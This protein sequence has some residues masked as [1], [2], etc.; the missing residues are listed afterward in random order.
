MDKKIS[1]VSFQ[2]EIDMLE[3]IIYAINGNEKVPARNCCRQ[4]NSEP[5]FQKRINMDG[6][7]MKTLL[8][9]EK[10]RHNWSCIPTKST[11]SEEKI[12]SG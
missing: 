9:P 11:H 1:L 4:I 2:E 6:S 10:C 12:K 5:V 8:V 7:G 3:S